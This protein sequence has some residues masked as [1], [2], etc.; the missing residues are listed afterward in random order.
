MVKASKNARVSDAEDGV[1]SR[2]RVFGAAYVNNL[3]VVAAETSRRG[4]PEAVGCEALLL[5]RGRRFH[6]LRQ[7]VPDG[8]GSLRRQLCATP[9]HFPKAE[10]AGS[11]SS[12]FTA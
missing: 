3:W 5:E 9:T 12:L 7:L 10:S 1:G 4:M 8:V 11:S 6:R 2:C